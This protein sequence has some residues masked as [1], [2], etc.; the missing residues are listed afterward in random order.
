M[1]INA[2]LLIY[3]QKF[4]V[5]KECKH[6]PIRNTRGNLVLVWE[7]WRRFHLKYLPFMTSIS[8]KLCS[9]MK[10]NKQKL[11]GAR[12]PVTIWTKFKTPSPINQAIRRGHDTATPR[13]YMA[14]DQQ[15]TTIAELRCTV[16]IYLIYVWRKAEAIS[17]TLKGNL[18]ETFVYRKTQLWSICFVRNLKIKKLFCI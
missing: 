10:A 13:F 4:K 7:N 17:W 12:F 6:D 18:W 15:K 9:L 2:N 3:H 5:E 8:F 16:S 11:L 1:E 14:R